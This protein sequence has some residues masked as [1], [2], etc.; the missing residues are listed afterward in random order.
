MYYYVRSLENENH[1]SNY[2]LYFLRFLIVFMQ[3]EPAFVDVTWGAG[4]STS[5][6]TTELCVNA[7][8]YGIVLV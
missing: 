1:L 5:D 4:G 8:N 3:L 7:Q 2:M 6:L